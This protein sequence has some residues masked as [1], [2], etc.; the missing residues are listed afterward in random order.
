[1]EYQLEC[2]NRGL[3]WLVE[4]RPYRLDSTSASNTGYLRNCAQ[5]SVSMSGDSTAQYRV[6]SDSSC[7]SVVTNWTNASGFIT[8]DNYIQLRVTTSST[9]N[10]TVTATLTLDLYGINWNATTEDF[11]YIFITSTT[12]NGNLKGSSS[13]GINGADAK[14]ATQATAGSLPG[15]YKAWVASGAGTNP[16]STFSQASASYR[17]HDASYTKVAN[18][19]TGL[20]SGT[21]LHTIDVW[22]NASSAGARVGSTNCTNW[23]SSSSGVNGRVGSSSATN[24]SWANSNQAA[25][26]G[27]K[28][29]YCVQQ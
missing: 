10:T 14:C 23:T 29:L 25:C 17:L 8:L 18:N 6:C 28:Q 27:T 9:A 1:M 4:S 11:K 21:L 2:Q 20:V 22:S 3:L 15:S 24:T 7:S 13:N 12:N 26:N 16:S 19:W 5:L